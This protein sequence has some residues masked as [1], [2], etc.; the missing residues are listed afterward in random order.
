MV[1]TVVGDIDFPRIDAKTR[2]SS[3]LVVQ[4]PLPSGARHMKGLPAV[5]RPIA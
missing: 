2:T 5:V 4:F 1:D 3:S